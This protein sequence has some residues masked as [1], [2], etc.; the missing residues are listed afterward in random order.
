M[1]TV[2]TRLKE[3]G[4]DYIFFWPAFLSLSLFL[5]IFFASHSPASIEKR[6]HGH[7]TAT[8]AAAF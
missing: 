3:R 8:A 5:Y 2:G 4:T 1:Y 6:E 7:P